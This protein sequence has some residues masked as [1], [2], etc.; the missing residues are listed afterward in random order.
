VIPT[1]FLQAWSTKAPWPDLRQVEQD[2]IICRALCD[3]FNAPALAGKIAF[4]T[5]VPGSGVR[6]L[7]GRGLSP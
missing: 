6:V 1:A 5:D 3:L 4:W 7:K 2:L